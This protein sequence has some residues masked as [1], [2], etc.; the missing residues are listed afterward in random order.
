MPLIRYRT[1]DLSRVTHNE[2]LCGASTLLK[3]GKVCK[4]L[5]PVVALSQGVSIYPSMF[6]EVVYHVPEVVDY[7]ITVNRNGKLEVLDLEVEVTNRER[8]FAGGNCG[9]D[10]IRS[11]RTG[12]AWPADVAPWRDCS[13]AAGGL[14]KNRQGQKGYSG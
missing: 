7:R 4:R 14:K 11:S 10:G 1:H 2:C 5:M 6:D 13:F 9:K 8:Q 12:S 3:I